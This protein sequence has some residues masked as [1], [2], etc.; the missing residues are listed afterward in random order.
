ARLPDDGRAGRG[1]RTMHPWKARSPGVERRAPGDR[2]ADVGVA[3]APPPPPGRP[4]AG[5]TAPA[6]GA[7]RRTG[8]TAVRQGRAGPPRRADRGRTRTAE[9][10]VASPARVSGRRR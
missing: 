8:L 7:P 3:P 1:F 2:V 6:L 10:A 9:A 5:R 4:P